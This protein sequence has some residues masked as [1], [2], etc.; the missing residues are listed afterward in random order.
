MPFQIR[1]IQLM[2]VFNTSNKTLAS[3]CNVDPSLVS[4]WRN[5]QR[6]PSLKSNQ[7][8]AIAQYFLNINPTIEQK[9]FLQEVLSIQ[10]LQTPKIIDTYDLLVQWLY[11]KPET[12][13]IQAP[14]SVQTP[15]SS[16][17]INKT[18]IVDE[19]EE[20]EK[21]L[22]R[23]RFPLSDQTKRTYHVFKENPGKRKAALLFLQKAL[24]LSEPTEIFIYSDE[25]AQWWL[26]DQLFQVQWTSYLKLIV[27]KNH[28]IHIIHDVNRPQDEFATY[29]NIWIPLHLI[30]SIS[31]YYHPHY[32]N[33]ALKETQM[34]IKNT[35][36]LVSNSTFLTPKENICF[37]YEDIETVELY[38]SLFLGR[39]VS[40]KPLIEVFKAQDQFR[41]LEL[42]IDS[43]SSGFPAT[44]L[45][46]HL[47]TFFLPDVVF[48]NYCKNWPKIKQMQYLRLI[49]KW[50]QEQ[51]HA[52]SRTSY[53]D[54]FPFE[55]LMEISSTKKYRHYDPIL[56][57]ETIIDLD[58]ELLKLTLKN[59]IYALQRYEYLDTYFIMK[60]SLKKGINLNLEL[61]EHHSLV[62]TT[63]YSLVSP[64]IGLYCHEGN[65]LNSF[66]HYLD[67]VISQIP[68]NLKNK[69]EAF[70]QLDRVLKQ[71][72][73]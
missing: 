27:M 23:P 65:M 2:N 15:Y 38:E 52:F 16:R 30:G 39:L 56:F 1:L 55:V 57:Q 62:F 29:L 19:E 6:V 71:L 21:A 68:S 11:Q 18:V 3:A 66:S 26:E 51:Y 48:E 44:A 31:S 43:V 47:N 73:Q 35:F 61:R 69:K 42:L 72:D 7:V 33:K 37:I 14:F 50:K 41:L 17:P 12:H 70:R 64:Y 10:K 22:L 54:V 4:R 32:V 40:C 20:T 67:S 46:A 5:G 9:Q 34:I 24:N 53:T 13:D 63:N 36:A 25:I 60:S 45:H 28:R 58:Q 59:M 8:Q 49:K